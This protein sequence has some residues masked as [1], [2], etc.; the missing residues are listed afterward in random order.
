MT[1]KVS[2]VEGEPRY[3]S[4]P[5]AKITDYPLEQRDYK[6]FAQ[7]SMCVSERFLH[8]RM[9]AFEVNPQPE[10]GLEAVLYLF[11]EKPGT[12]LAVV[13][14]SDDA[15]SDSSML[16]GVFLLRDGQEQATPKQIERRFCE[17]LLHPYNGEDLQGVYWG[18]TVD[19][20]LS[21]LEEWGG[22][23]L[24]NPGDSFPG[25]FYKICDAGPRPH[26]GSFFPADFMGNGYLPASCGTMEVVT[27]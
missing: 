25:N 7:V 11:R 8:L 26:S 10:S 12:A 13:A 20:P 22:G 5:V 23:L 18:Y 2:R 24:L 19:I 15:E 4:L 21:L 9:W 16:L 3:D 17:I 27:Y 1:F 6:P 14:V